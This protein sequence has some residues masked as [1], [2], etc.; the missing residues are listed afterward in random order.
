MPPLLPHARFETRIGR[1]IHIRKNHETSYSVELG[2]YGLGDSFGRGRIRRGTDGAAGGI[3]AVSSGARNKPGR[4]GFERGGEFEDGAT[5]YTR[6]GAVGIR[7][8]G[9]A[10]GQLEIPR[11]EQIEFEDRR[12]GAFRG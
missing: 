6:Y 4:N 8:C 12:L 11:A 2:G 7:T 5:G 1:A 10:C 9:R 3:F